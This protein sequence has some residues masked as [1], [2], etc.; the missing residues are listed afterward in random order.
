MTLTLVRLAFSGMRFRLLATGLTVVLA[1]AAAATVVLALQ[2]GETI[3]DPW[4]RTFDASHGAHVLVIASSH[5]QAR[6]L[7]NA[8]G[9][10]EAAA[11][12]P[13]AFSGIRLATPGGPEP[14]Q[15][16]SLSGR[17]SVNAPVRISGTTTPGSGIVL[18]RSLADALGVGVGTSLRLAGPDAERQLPVVGT[19]VVPSQG[20]YPRVNPGIGWVSEP[21]L[22][23]LEADQARW[24]W[25]V[26][27]RLAE[28][29]ASAGVA[30]TILRHA[31]GSTVS[32]QTWED[33]RNDALKDVEPFRLVLT[34]Y[35]MVLLGVVFIVVAILVGA[36]ALQQ[37]REI[38]VLKAV[39]LS[40]PQVTS[41][42]VIESTALGLIG[43]SLGFFVGTLLAPRVAQAAA[44]SLLGS[45]TVA[46]DPLALLLAVAPVTLVLAISSWASTRHRTQ[47]SVVQAV[48]AG[49]AAPPDESRLGTLVSALP[50][51]APVVVG[52]RTV[53]AGRGRLA[54][55]A[56]ATCLT[57]ATL[58][59]ALSMQ[60]SF[61]A[62]PAGQVSDVPAELPAVVYTL[63]AVL[64][65][66]A[67]TS[68]LAVSLLTLRER[69][70]DFAV[71]K[72]MGLTPRQVA[73]TLVA[74]Y[75]VMALVSALVSVPL[76][77]AL[78]LAAF[79]ASGSDSDPTLAS[80]AVMA[81]VPVGMTLLVVVVVAAPARLATRI[82]AAVALRA[83]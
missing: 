46:V 41:I 28:P 74:P 6:S 5:E 17:P 31:P 40:P 35:A 55:L 18:E 2:V 67:L 36:R 58:V 78:F 8:A 39:G 73:S 25:L 59:F 77:I 16:L 38:G 19:A 83:E 72:A 9:V 50:M 66:I 33:Q 32:V 68:L 70:R 4:Q 76:G 56:T 3:R 75:A 71:L 57:G 10:T 12:V 69:L 37:H 62:Q 42:F 21:T 45:P 44:A 54:L 27:M 34:M 14:V 30:T 7:R 81:V 11:P 23:D 1:C 26:A 60:A 29:E 47:F 24:H 79:Y 63:D 53:L 80:A 65:V 61:A 64:V 13:Y 43:S 48:E 15:L 82:P 49:R 20:R 51:P 22:R 52:T